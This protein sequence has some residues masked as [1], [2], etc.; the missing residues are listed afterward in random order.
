[1]FDKHARVFFRSKE[2]VH[3][4]NK[5]FSTISNFYYNE[6]NHLFSPLI[7]FASRCHA[8]RAGLYE[9]ELPNKRT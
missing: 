5:Q 1:M 7:G 2:I 4:V 9:Q 6:P 3:K 8:A